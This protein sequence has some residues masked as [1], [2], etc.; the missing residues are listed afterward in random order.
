MYCI[1][2]CISDELRQQWETS[3]AQEKAAIQEKQAKEIQVKVH[4]KCWKLVKAVKLCIAILFHSWK[5]LY[6]IEFEY[7]FQ[8]I[9]VFLHQDLRS[10]WNKDAESTQS[11]HQSSLSEMQNNLNDTQKELASTQ[12][13]LTQTN[14]ALTEAQVALSETQTELQESLAKLEELQ[15]SNNVQKQKLEEEL[16]QAWADRDSVA[17]ELYPNIF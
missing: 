8:F 2:V 7:T 12:V 1:Y 14:K 4:K 15:T 13:S 16:K 10:K 9:L 17:C 11:N 3:V 6:L 5:L